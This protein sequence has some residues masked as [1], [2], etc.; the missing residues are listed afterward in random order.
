[1]SNEPHGI[2]ALE[3]DWH[4]DLSRQAGVRPLLQLVT[5][6]VARLSLVHRD[7]GT[8]EEIRYYSGR[9]SLAQYKHFSVVYLAFHGTPGHIKVGNGVIELVGLGE[10]LGDVCRG[11]YV[12]FGSCSTVRVSKARIAAFKEQ[13]GALAV[14]G[15]TRDVDWLE[16]AAF[17]VLLMGAMTFYKNP[18]SV[19]NYM[20]K[21]ALGLGTKL[22]WTWA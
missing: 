8:V 5:E 13:T 14:S 1:M 19:K 7:V 6:Q 17:E 4:H 2:F 18:K 20:D 11:R 12:H 3:G 9:V 16:S 10:A 21:L 15:Y 22:G